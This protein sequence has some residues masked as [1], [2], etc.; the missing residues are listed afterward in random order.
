M[1]AV[2]L[3]CGVGGV[4]SGLTQAGYQ[5]L[6]AVELD[7]GCAQTHLDNFPDCHVFNGDLSILKAEE[8]RKFSAISD[9][10]IEICWASP[11]CQSFSLAGKRKIGD[12]RSLL[13][14]KSCQLIIDLNPKY[15]VIENVKGLVMS[16]Q[17]AFL[18]EAIDYLRA[19]NYNVL[20]YE[21][22]NAKDYGVPQSRERVIVIGGRKDVPLPA[23]PEPQT[24]TP[25]IRDAIGDLPKIENYPELWDS[26]TVQAEYGKPSEYAKQLI[27]GRGQEDGAFKV[28]K[29]LPHTA[30]PEGR[31]FAPAEPVSKD[32]SATEGCGK[33]KFLLPSALCPLPSKRLLTYS[34][35]TKHS[36]VIRERFNRTPANT[37]EPVSRFFKLD[38]NGIS[39][40]LRAGSG[41]FTAIRPIHPESPRVCTV[42][43]L[44]RLQS[45]DD[46]FIFAK[47]K[48]HACRQIGNSV[49][50]L[51]VKAIVEKLVGSR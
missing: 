50:P 20:D 49:P 40:T 13:L 26:D 16:A 1:I 5:V 39:N 3:F 31:G 35:R 11:P 12:P 10:E 30:P 19:N 18:I 24:Y 42:R 15:F 43:E 8:I 46:G 37:I 33:E 14:L 4:S 41:S 48:L 47:S 32:S 34:Q 45:F 27:E 44:A 7:R 29:T 28:R 25:T 6:A 23:Y 2:D 36:S 21:I 9:R 38:W 22:L 17:K 51:M